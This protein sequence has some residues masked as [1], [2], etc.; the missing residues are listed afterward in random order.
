MTYCLR[1]WIL[2]KREALGEIQAANWGALPSRKHLRSLDY[3]PKITAYS[4]K[5]TA[6]FKASA[7]FSPEVP[8]AR[9]VIEVNIAANLAG[10]LQELELLRWAVGRAKRY[11]PASSMFVF[12]SPRR[13]LIH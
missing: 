13:R 8:I 9:A 11:G 2:L 4:L 3:H 7:R 1:C 10:T 6:G 5:K 12:P